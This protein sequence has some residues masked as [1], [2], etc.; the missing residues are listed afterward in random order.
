MYAGKASQRTMNKLSPS[1]WAWSRE[2]RCAVDVGRVDCQGYEDIRIAL[3]QALSGV[4][5]AGPLRALHMDSAL[6]THVYAYMHAGTQWRWQMP[7][8]CAAP[9][10]KTGKHV[11]VIRASIAHTRLSCYRRSKVEPLHQDLEQ[12]LD[13]LSR[14]HM[15]SPR[16]AA[17]VNLRWDPNPQVTWVFHT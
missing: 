17:A 8:A 13:I 9:W 5:G 10:T 7:L 4:Y 2:H 15:T 6:A 1:E 12:V 3:P 11:T 16:S 14:H